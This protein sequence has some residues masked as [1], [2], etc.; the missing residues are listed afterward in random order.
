MDRS[1][2]QGRPADPTPAPWPDP[3]TARLVAIAVGV[4][5]VVVGLAVYLATRTD[6]FYDHFVWQAAGVH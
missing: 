4:G 6:R 5:L 3:R 2:A 1:V